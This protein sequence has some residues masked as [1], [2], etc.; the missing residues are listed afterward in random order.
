MK[1]TAAE[2]ARLEIKARDEAAPR[3]I[4][5]VRHALVWVEVSGNIHTIGREV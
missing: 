3:A 2:I 5:L 1:S 4:D